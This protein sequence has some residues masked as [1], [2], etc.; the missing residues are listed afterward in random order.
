M[1]LTLVDVYMMTGLDVAGSMY[2]YKY[3][4]SIRQSGVKQDLDIN[5]ISKTICLMVL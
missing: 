3:K 5:N 2:P 1:S 4:T